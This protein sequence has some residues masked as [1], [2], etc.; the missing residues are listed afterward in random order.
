MRAT[1]TRWRLRDG[2]III[3][4]F[5]GHEIIDSQ[6][7]LY[8]AIPHQYVDALA[9][10][11]MQVSLD[12]IIPPQL[13]M[14]RDLGYVVQGTG[15]A[16]PQF[17]STLRS[18]DH[19]FLWQHPGYPE[20]L[21]EYALYLHA[22]RK[23]F[24]SDLVQGPC[25]PE[26]TLR[27]ALMLWER[28]RDE[29][30]LCLGDDDL[31]SLI[32]ARLGVS[33]TVVDLHGALLDF[34]EARAAEAAVKLETH[35]YDIRLPLPR[36]LR[37]RFGAVITDPVSEEPWLDLWLSRSIQ[38]LR[39]EG[40]IYLS[41]Y[42]GY[43]NL[44]RHVLGK[45]KLAEI[46]MW[47]GFSHYYD[48]YLRHVPS[49]NSNLFV[50]GLTDDSLPVFGDAA[51]SNVDLQEALELTTEYT[52]DFYQCNPVLR[53]EEC[54][55][56]LHKGFASLATMEQAEVSVHQKPDFWS[57]H[58]TMS[59]MLVRLLIYP[60]RQYVGLNV[61]ARH[62]TAHDDQWLR[63]VYEVVRPAVVTDSEIPRYVQYSSLR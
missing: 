23:L 45:M 12:S 2:A 63:I 49:W 20:D 56:L 39:R 13:E 26:S 40:R 58:V 41:T 50:V 6:R 8:E 9:K 36:Q 42:P 54:V 38:A 30:V 27:R 18:W 33:V 51:T 17:A 43:E 34:L 15:M 60:N 4:R 44:T 32:L 37:S 52:L 14:L 53:W 11:A 24:S 62:E 29:E 31:V 46:A 19:Q 16:D 57:V 7:Y 5:G 10:I 59:D 35:L 55:S 21:Y 1:D 22:T 25:L 28:H 3:S 47:S 48:E 61:L